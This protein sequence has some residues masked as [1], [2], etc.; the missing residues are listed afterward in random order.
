MRLCLDVSN[1]DLPLLLFRKIVHSKELIMKQGDERR[2]QKLFLQFNF[3]YLLK[4]SNYNKIKVHYS[5]LTIN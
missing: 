5:Q 1:D 2:V 3:T 4:S